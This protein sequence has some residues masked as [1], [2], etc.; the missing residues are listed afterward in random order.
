MECLCGTDQVACTCGN[1]AC[2]RHGRCCECVANHR[3]KGQLPGCLM[4]EELRASSRSVADL[5]KYYGERG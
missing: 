1:T 4:P 2:S 5:V 3:E